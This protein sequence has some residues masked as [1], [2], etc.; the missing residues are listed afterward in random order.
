M[1]GNNAA[2]AGRVGQAWTMYQ[3]VEPCIGS[4]AFWRLRIDQEIAIQ[5]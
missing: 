5:L 1:E 3:F 2:F 4:V